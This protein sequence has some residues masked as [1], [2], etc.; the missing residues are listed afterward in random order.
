MKN[1]L[2]LT[3]TLSSGGAERQMTTIACLLKNRGYNVS[4]LCFAKGD[5]FYNKILE[6]EHIQI[7]KLLKSNR[8]STILAVREYVRKGSF[9]VVISFL[10]VPNLLNN[11]AA[12]GGKKWIVITGE[13]S[14]KLST[15]RSFKGRMFS[16]LRRYSD[17]IVCNS[18]NASTLW[19]LYYPRF[20][21]KLRVIYNT[22]TLGAINNTYTPLKNGII[23]MVVAASYQ[24]TKNPAKVVKA[25]LMLNEAERERLVIDWYGRKDFAKGDTSIYDKANDIVKKYHLEKTI[26]LHNAT[27]DIANKM[28]E[29]D[30]VALF[31]SVEGLPNTICEAMTIGK[32]VVMTKVSD[33]DRLIGP[34]NGLLCSSVSEKSICNVLRI[35]LSLSKERVLQMGL[36]SKQKANNLFSASSV[37]ENWIRLIES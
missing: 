5:E 13:R 28:N 33:Y 3:A 30:M 7:D 16:F 27:S 21:S 34:D 32:P 18:E 11:I 12:I 14:S 20:E 19:K 35:A 23:H 8:L 15:F 31:S 24:D 9:D 26:I 10:S 22:V 29:S 37:C 6:N 4:F 2:F 1:I 36:S 17:Y 25:V